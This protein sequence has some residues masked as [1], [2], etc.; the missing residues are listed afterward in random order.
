[1]SKKC[2]PSSSSKCPKNSPLFSLGS[3]MSPSNPS[4]VNS[5][6]VPGLPEFDPNLSGLRSLSPSYPSKV[7]SGFVPGLPKFDRNLSG[8][9]RRRLL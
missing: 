6:A 3:S 5:G 1:M 9:R 4:K 8:L 2:L 7:N